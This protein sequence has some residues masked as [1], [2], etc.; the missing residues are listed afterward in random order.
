MPCQGLK[1]PR[2]EMK[3][4]ECIKTRCRDEHKGKTRGRTALA[5]VKGICLGVMRN[6]V[7]VARGHMR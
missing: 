3:N 1:W 5:E 6:E 2:R 4:L 7:G